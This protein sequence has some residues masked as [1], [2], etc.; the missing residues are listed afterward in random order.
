[1][2]SVFG[3]I[4]FPFFALYSAT[5][6]ALRGYSEAL[7]RE[8][9]PQGI[10]VTYIAPRAART[11][12]SDGFPCADRAD[13]D[14]AGHARGRRPSRLARH[15]RAQAR[16]VPA[17]AVNAFSSRCNALAPRLIDKNLIKLARDP[18]VIAAARAPILRTE[19]LMHYNILRQR[20]F[21]GG[22]TDDGLQIRIRD[23][24]TRD[25][26]TLLRGFQPGSGR[27]RRSGQHALPRV[28]FDPARNNATDKT[29]M[30]DAGLG[31]IGLHIENG[32]T[33]ALPRYRLPSMPSARPSRAR[34]PRSATGCA[35]W[36]RFDAARKA[37]W[38]QKMTVERDLPELLWKRYLANEHPAISRPEEVTM[39]HV[40]QFQ[41]AVPGQGFDLHEDGSLTYR[42]TCW[43]RC[44]ARPLAARGGA[45]PMRCWDR[46]TTISRRAISWRMARR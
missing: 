2:G 31:P 34:R 8:L 35:V 43:I 23:D 42:L 26:W 1:M 10:A 7:R 27:V 24:L 17:Q 20:D 13:G 38:S 14:G 46:R 15:R 39:E 9:A 37:R 30:V 32:N 40:L 25:G 28:T 21:A 36:D 6:F 44:A 45:L 3:D 18:A 22:L 4:G 19:F 41:Q 33:P 5:K 12:A 16:T 11:E 29:Q